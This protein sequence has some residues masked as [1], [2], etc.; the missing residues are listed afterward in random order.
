MKK[1]LHSFQTGQVCAGMLALVLTIL[2]ASSTAHAQTLGDALNATNL[3]WTSGGNGS[4]TVTTASAHDGVAAARS[5]VITHSQQ[6]WVQTSVAGP[7]TLSFWWATSS[8]GTWDKLTFYVDGAV[9]A[10]ISGETGWSKMIKALTNGTHVLKWVY[11]KDGSVSSGSDV[12]WL[13]EV[14]LSTVPLWTSQP[15]STNLFSGEDVVLAGVATGVGTLSY[16]WMKDGVALTNREGLHGVNTASLEITNAAILD[17]GSYTLAVSNQN[18]GTISQPATLGVSSNLITGV[19]GRWP[20]HSRTNGSSRNVVLLNSYALVA[21]LEG[22]LQVLDVADPAAPALSGGFDT[23]DWTRDVALRGNYALLADGYNGVQVLD[24][25]DPTDTQWVAAHETAGSARS[26]DITGDLLCVADASAGLQFFNVLDPAHPSW[27]GGYNTSGSAEG[28]AVYGNYALVADGY[29]GLQVINLNNPASPIRTGGLD[30]RGYSRDVTAYDH[31]ALVADGTNGLQVIDLSNPA[32]PTFASEFQTGGS[33]KSVGLD[34]TLAFVA[35]DARGI[36][37]LDLADPLNPQLVGRWLRDGGVMACLVSSNCL[38]APAGSNGMFTLSLASKV[39]PSAP[40]ILSTPL[41]ASV[42]ERETVTLAARVSGSEPLIYQWFRDGVPVHDDPRVRG[43]TNATLLI[44]SA[45]LS[46]SGSYSLRAQ[47]GYG[48][49]NTD[50][51]QLI[52]NSNMIVGTAG[53]WPGYDRAG[54]YGIALS[55]DYAVC[56]AGS[57]GV[58]VVDIRD[59]LNPARVGAYRTAGFAGSVVA[60]DRYAF[61][62]DASIGFQVL[63]LN[64]PTQP[65][66]VAVVATGRAVTGMVLDGTHLITTEGAAGLHLYDISNPLQ[67]AHLGGMDTEGSASG[68]ALNGHIACVAD[69]TGGALFV[70]VSDPGQ[71]LLLGR[72]DLLSARSVAWAGSNVLV[73][74]DYSISIFDVSNLTNALW[75]G[76][77]FGGDRIWSQVVVGERIFVANGYNGLTELDLAEPTDPVV[78]A[79]WATSGSCRGAAI[80]GSYAYVADATKGLLVVDISTPGSLPWMPNPSTAGYAQ[81][82]VAAGSVAY[83]S[84]GVAGWQTLDISNP[85]LPVQT[86][87]FGTNSVIVDTALSGHR[88]YVIDQN[89][90]VLAFNRAD[91]FHPV[92]ECSSFFGANGTSIA[93]QSTNIYVAAKSGGLSVLGAANPTALTELGWVPTSDW[94][95]DASVQGTHAFV[96]DGYAG[97]EIYDASVSTNLTRVGGCVTGSS[98]RG[99]LVSGDYAYVAADVAGLHVINVSDPTRPVLVSTRPLMGSATAVA[100]FG[101]FVVVAGGNGGVHLFDVSDPSSPVRVGWAKTRD[102]A[103]DVG[104]AGRHIL[105]ADGSWGVMVLELNPAIEPPQITE[106]PADSVG[107]LGD[108]RSFTVAATGAEP[109]RYQ[110]LHDGTAIPDAT[111]AVLVLTNLARNHAGGYSARV[112]NAVGS[113]TSSN[114][115][116]TL[117]VPQ[118]LRSAAVLPDGRLQFVSGWADDWPVQQEDFSRFE[119]QS[120]TNLTSWVSSSIPLVLTN[121]A[122]IFNDTNVSSVPQ[123]YYRVIER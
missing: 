9:V 41:P 100:G 99:L 8:E 30:T 1:K 82:V 38:Y 33:V 93:V 73:S 36:Y 102:S 27:I 108:E 14:V 109:L 110:W 35:D 49:T 21:D 78:T 17:S 3:V 72:I 92:L 39:Q 96:S 37:V 55:G 18:G 74:D 22:G 117:R 123:R 88:A 53:N 116:L 28:V 43:S 104:L 6:S 83:V 68:V 101:R 98:A 50:P 40:Q 118:R 71:L 84:D 120:S 77:W 65:S 63:D 59:P 106:Q 29:S 47:N 114:A 2:L 69:N 60:N 95:W 115:T 13:D 57:K 103:R 23:T 16:Q 25:S 67:S 97:L 46:D 62:A 20:G 66:A 32:A 61:V 19:L 107:A 48:T 113:D 51:A 75:Q 111:N 54:I 12:G 80:R 11:S 119:V 89:H 70:D 15:A 76:D 91:P 81:S 24:V 56:A 85:A 79:Q 4:W 86:A 44:D 122:L 42:L 105:V 121:G 34:H 64:D 90:G 5:G 31:Y 94:A 26:L 58:F 52:V 112:T 87:S 7:I 10:Y 45:H